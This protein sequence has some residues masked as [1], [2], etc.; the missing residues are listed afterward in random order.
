MKIGVIVKPD[1]SNAA[2]RAITPM[3]ALGEC[4]HE[5]VLAKLGTGG[6]F[7]LRDLLTCDVVHVYRCSDE[8][9]VVKGVDE[10]RRR[11]VA[12]TWDDDVNATA[13]IGRPS[14]RC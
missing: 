2:Y 7:A 3:L 13:T 9:G 14:R 11:G 8:R 12:I 1:V 6:K 4:G 10:L 5:V